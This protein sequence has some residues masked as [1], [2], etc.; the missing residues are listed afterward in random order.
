MSQ[1]NKGFGSCPTVRIKGEDGNPII[2]NK[3]DFNK[4]IHVL[5]DAV[6]TPNGSYEDM[7]KD[8]LA[9]ELNER[10][11][12]FSMSSTK[13]VLISLLEEDDNGE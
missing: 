8:E 11:V 13:A 2:I 6:D 1:D 3:E 4:E 10:D 7:T 5:F 9:A 12:E